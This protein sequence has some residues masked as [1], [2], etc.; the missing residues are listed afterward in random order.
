MYKRIFKAEGVEVNAVEICVGYRKS[1]NSM[2]DS[3]NIEGGY[4]ASVIPLYRENHDGFITTRVSAGSG[5]NITILPCE[6][7]SSKRE[8]E[9]DSIAQKRAKEFLDILCSRNSSVKIT[10]VVA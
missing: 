2:W 3:S 1:G 8:A 6:R 10:E 4:Y 9:A 5:F 7:R